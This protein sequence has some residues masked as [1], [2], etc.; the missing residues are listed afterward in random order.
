MYADLIVPVHGE[1]VAASSTVVALVA[2]ERVFASVDERVLGYVGVF[3]SL[4]TT[5]VVSR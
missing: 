2:L 4:I 5:A 3:R 1:G